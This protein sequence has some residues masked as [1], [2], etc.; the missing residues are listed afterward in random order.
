[1]TSAGPAGR[2]IHVRRAKN[3]TVAGFPDTI[4][5]KKIKLGMIVLLIELYLLIPLSETLTMYQD[6]RGV[7]QF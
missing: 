4:N 7:K 1:M 3:F 6:H 5:V 2:M